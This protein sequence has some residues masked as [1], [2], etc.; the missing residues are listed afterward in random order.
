MARWFKDV[1]PCP[2]EWSVHGQLG[3]CDCQ[4][5][6]E[7]KPVGLDPCW[8]IAT[9]VM[10]VSGDLKGTI[11]K[12]FDAVQFIGL[13]RSTL[14]SLCL[15]CLGIGLFV[16]VLYSLA[17]GTPDAGAF[18]RVIQDKAVDYCRKH[19]QFVWSH[20]CLMKELLCIPLKSSFELMFWT[21]LPN[22]S[23]LPTSS[24]ILRDSNGSQGLLRTEFVCSSHRPPCHSSSWPGRGSHP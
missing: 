23:F 6:Y 12:G 4:V 13:C 3:C 10:S 21:Y 24:S 8:P 5:L 1:Q 9:S 18:W 2:W 14:C 16:S 22:R 17:R 20:S 7:G 19:A 15:D 11:L